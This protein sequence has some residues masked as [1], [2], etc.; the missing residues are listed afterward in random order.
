MQAPLRALQSPLRLPDAAARAAERREQRQGADE[1]VLVARGVGARE[2]LARL[3]HLLQP[4]R[5]QRDSGSVLRRDK[6]TD[7]RR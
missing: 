4:G 3:N 6:Q 1:R 2:V 5:S 7:R